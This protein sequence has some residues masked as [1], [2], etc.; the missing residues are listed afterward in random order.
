[1]P[2][3]AKILVSMS[4]V[5]T[6]LGCLTNPCVNGQCLDADNADG[7]TCTCYSGYLGARCDQVD[8]M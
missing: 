1:M 7:Y 4:F 8:R 5:C 3:Q 6:I 2:K